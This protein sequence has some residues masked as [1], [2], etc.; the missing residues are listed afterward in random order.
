[1]RPCL[2]SGI[3]DHSCKIN[4]QKCQGAEARIRAFHKTRRRGAE[5]LQYSFVIWGLKEGTIFKSWVPKKVALSDSKSHGRLLQFSTQQ[6]P[7][8]K[9]A[10]GYTPALRLKFRGLNNRIGVLGEI[11]LYITGYKGILL[12]ILPTPISDKGP[13]TQ[14]VGRTRPS[15]LARQPP[16]TC[17]GD[18]ED[19]YLEVH[20]WL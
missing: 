12:V 10:K 11:L 1:M 7:T 5:T 3:S 8:Q 16:R 18:C 20:G 17:L 14:T 6:T 15:C 2:G 9:H 19:G 13:K 4:A